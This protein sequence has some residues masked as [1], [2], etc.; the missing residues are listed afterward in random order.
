M[1]NKN[2]GKMKVTRKLWSDG[3]RYMLLRNK[4]SA[5][6]VRFDDGEIILFFAILQLESTPQHWVLPVLVLYLVYHRVYKFVGTL[7]CTVKCS[8]GVIS[9]MLQLQEL[10]RRTDIPVV[11]TS[12][13]VQCVVN[14]ARVAYQNFTRQLPRE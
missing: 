12:W 9:L 3:V 6:M 2:S 11:S 10:R 5:K 14:N 4:I 1:L 8:L 7:H 13:V